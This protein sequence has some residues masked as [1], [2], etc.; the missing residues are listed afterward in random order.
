MKFL[1]FMFA[2]NII[3]DIKYSNSLKG[4]NIITLGGSQP[5][6]PI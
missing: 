2:L 3:A 4:S 5:N 1:S 6:S